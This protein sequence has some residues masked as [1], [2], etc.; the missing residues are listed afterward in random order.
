M[1]DRL[2]SPGGA[3]QPR[4]ADR[5]YGTGGGGGD[6]YFDTRTITLLNRIASKRRAMEGR[7]GRGGGGGAGGVA[8]SESNSTATALRRLLTPSF[9]PVPG[10]IG[11]IGRTY[12]RTG[13]LPP[14]GVGSRG[15]AMSGDRSSVTP[16]SLL[17]GKPAPQ[18]SSAAAASD[19]AKTLA[20]SLSQMH[21]RERQAAGGLM[22]G[23]GEMGGVAGTSAAAAE[24][25][26]SVPGGPRIPTRTQ[27]LR[28]RPASATPQM[29]RSDGTGVAVHATSTSMGLGA[30]TSGR[31]ADDGAAWRGQPSTGWGSEPASPAGG[32]HAE[33]GSWWSSGAAPAVAQNDAAGSGAA[34]SDWADVAAP[35]AQSASGL[36]SG[37]NGGAHQSGAVGFDRAADAAPS[38][39]ARKQAVAVAGPPGIA[40]SGRVGSLGG[41]LGTVGAGQS[42]A[43]AMTAAVQSTAGVSQG[44]SIAGMSRLTPASR[45]PELSATPKV[46]VSTAPS[47][48]AASVSAVPQ[49]RRIQIHVP[50]GMPIPADGIIF[51]E[52]PDLMGLTVVFR[53]PEAR[54]HNPDRLNLDR[55]KLESCPQL[56]GET[57]LRLLNYQNNLIRTISNLNNLPHLI[58]LDLYNNNVERIMNL[59]AVPALR[60]LMLG[61]NN[62][63]RIEN[64]HSCPKLD[65]LDLHS[66]QIEKIEGLSHLLE[67]RVLNLAG[68]LIKTATNLEALAVLTELNLRRNQI[69]SVRNLDMLPT[70]QRLFLSNN[71]LPDLASVECIF[72]L[73][74]LVEL[75]L[76]GNPLVGDDPNAYRQ[77]IVRRLRSVKHI[78]LRRVTEEERRGA[79]LQERREENRRL[80][81]ARA[82]RAADAREYA[83]RAVQALWTKDI[84][85]Q[86]QREADRSTQ[87]SPSPEAVDPESEPVSQ[88]AAAAAAAATAA[89]RGAR[90]RNARVADVPVPGTQLGG[91]DVVYEEGGERGDSPRG[92]G[93]GA[94]GDPAAIRVGLDKM[95]S[96]L[97][98]FT[99]LGSGPTARAFWELEQHDEERRH[100]R[101]FGQ[102][103]DGLDDSKIQRQATVL[104]ILYCPFHAL[105]A[106]GLKR[107]QGLAR[108]GELRLYHNNMRTLVDLR[109]LAA[110]L[111]GGIKRLRIESNPVCRLHL[112]RLYSVHLFKNVVEL[113]GVEISPA[114]RR[115]ALSMFGP[116]DLVLGS[117]RQAAPGVSAAGDAGLHGWT[118]GR[119]D[120]RGSLRLR[121][122]NR[123]GRT[124][125]PSE[126]W[127]VR[128]GTHGDRG[129]NIHGHSATEFVNDVI[130]HGKMVDVRT[131]SLN[132][133][134]PEVLRV[135][136]QQT[137]DDLAPGRSIELQKQLDAL[138]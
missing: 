73:S 123:D 138:V 5:G 112:F 136:V 44:P 56:E 46:P 1:A 61:K 21:V 45:A 106:K 86:I 26:S 63:T 24:R 76:D 134:W 69:T 99:S 100:C 62:I 54:A 22:T 47:G 39:L 102:A 101:M 15:A 10:G 25:P 14:A 13:T 68:N 65:V 3:G 59:E 12:D 133:M 11:S 121:D 113:N 58:F 90:S 35:A 41:G 66:N 64:L 7:D 60:V 31:G 2:P 23:M 80:E 53:T 70:L 79:E 78:D 129:D 105:A 132:R 38:T 75:A 109:A 42:V 91:S 51:A 27:S 71:R 94:D 97:A 49:Q 122:G 19:R 30:G 72:G 82:Q 9:S 36:P 83:I 104:S 77:A 16:L 28:M 89:L 107:L 103:F 81:H 95:Y 125:T 93:S 32:G 8:Y 34:G 135:L 114:E 87:R 57:Q 29:R 67:L 20:R 111:P 48:A 119:D 50:P 120:G 6:S 137:L 52:C 118:A 130:R 96:N 110:K 55:R 43:P 108:L 18:R 37:Q 85:M 74:R 128:G 88:T 127:G 131:R 117:S 116:I 98:S 4:R 17:S 33:H 40:D 92:D 124:G 84:E 126:P 115:A